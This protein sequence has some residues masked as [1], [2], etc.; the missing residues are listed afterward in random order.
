MNHSRIGRAPPDV[1][2]ATSLYDA[3]SDALLRHKSLTALIEADR[4]REVT[5]WTYQDFDRTARR[6]ARALEEQ[7]VGAGDRVAVLATNQ[8][9][10]L[11]AAYAVFRR[12]GVLVPLDYKLEAPEQLALLAHA[13]PRGLVVDY[14]LWRRFAERP[15][16]PAIWVIGA[17][18]GEELPGALRFEDLPEDEGE[19]VP[20]TRSD[21]ATIVYSSGTG[22]RPKGCQLTHG[23]Y[24]AQLDGLLER[25]PMEPGDRYFSV[26]PTNHAI[27]FMVGFVGPF[28]CGAT[29]V[30]QRALRPEMLRF[31]M[32]RYA[33]SHMAVVPLLLEAF[34]RAAQE[35]LDELPGWQRQVVDGLVAVN[36]SL[37]A[38][39]PNHALSSRLLAPI[40]RAF[41]GKLKLLF[42]G[43]AFTD[44][45]HAEFF[46]Q[47]G[48]PVVIGYGLTEAC[49]VVTVNGVRPLRADS[50]GL[51]VR[52][53]EV[54]IDDAGDGVGEV[55]VR[56]ATLMSGYLDDPELTAET[57]QDGWLHTGDLGWLD[58][59]GHLHLCGRMK[60]VIVTAGGKNV[61]PEDVEHAFRGLPVD[62]V[63]VFAANTLWPRRSMQHEELVLV[64][65]G[66]Q[67]L[68]KLMPELAARNRQL[69]D[70][71][72]VAAVLSWSEAFPRT[73]SMK[74]KRKELAAS[75]GGRATRDQASPLGAVSQDPL[76]R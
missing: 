43:G 34:Q 13:R 30:H 19:P 9:S 26:L 47:L 53:V 40:H 25:F 49:T 21:L 71:K 8:P 5:R 33:I 16:V 27:D 55:W 69:P 15:D 17:P 22:G 1:S 31:T 66:E 56:G 73:A 58:A 39:G 50:V 67:P 42:C 28:V 41:G 11:L 54:H 76:T 59:S 62:E 14:A 32:Q 29:V 35:R 12:G 60:D 38:R 70:Y 45:T 36:R 3:L 72:R 7:H 75:L 64:V 52:G 46:D 2:W 74:V 23:A 68:A 6:V 57:V 51:P 4:K 44:R 37:T 18:A 65:R 20:R 63:A 61:Y 10:W 24:L 48:I